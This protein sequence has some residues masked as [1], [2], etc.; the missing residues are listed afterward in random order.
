MGIVPDFEPFAQN[1]G[2]S[3]CFFTVGA[4]GSRERTCRPNFQRDARIGYYSEEI[5]D[6]TSLGGLMRNNLLPKVDRWEILLVI[7]ELG[8]DRL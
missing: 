6:K 8:S 5:P 1:A 3:V 4:E 7:R 2:G